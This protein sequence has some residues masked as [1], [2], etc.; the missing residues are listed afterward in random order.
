MLTLDRSNGSV[1]TEL[2]RAALGPIHTDYYLSAFTGFDAAGKT[3]VH[4]NWAAALASLNWML[5]RQLWTHALAYVGALTTA[6]LLFFGIGRLV[7]GLSSASQWGLMGLAL[8]LA[9]ALPGALGNAWL[10]AVCNRRIEAALAKAA[11]TE[12]ACTLLARGASG[13]KQQ[14]ALLAGNLVLGTA[15]CALVLAWPSAS[16]FS[17][18]SAKL[19]RASQ[20]GLDSLARSGLAAQNVAAVTALAPV[21]ASASTV[22]SSSEPAFTPAPAVA[23]ASAAEASAGAAAASS[24]AM[25]SRSSQ[26]LVQS[27][28]NRAAVPAQAAPSTAASAVVPGASAPAAAKAAAE[29]QK[30][31]SATELRAAAA[32]SKKEKLAKIKEAKEAMAAKA[33]ASQASAPA[34]GAYLINVGLFADANN[35]RNAYTRLQDAGLAAIKQELTSAKGLIRTRVRV[36]PFE[37]QA[38]AEAAAEK[39]RALKLE[40]A[41]FKR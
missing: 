36:G 15:M 5:F 34:G 26:G 14:G 41:V 30:K 2:Y 22:A 35:A 20:P 29:V 17:K 7:F 12:E 27:A 4:W 9:F 19:E 37:S 18:Q 33:P 39:I 13:R 8:L 21:P 38:E 11:S 16:N 3:A 10:Y 28:A 25:A 31:P 23:V 1:T 40:A 24:P 6:L 32:Q